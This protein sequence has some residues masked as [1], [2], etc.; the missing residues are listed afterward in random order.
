MK[1]YEKLLLLRNIPKFGNVKINKE[2]NNLILQ[3]ESLSDFVGDLKRSGV[4]EDDIKE[5]L[6]K[7]EQTKE[8]ISTIDGL[9]IITIYDD[10]YPERFNALGNSKPVILYAIGDVA[11]LREETMA[12]IGTRHPGEYTRNV[13]RRIINKVVKERNLV[14]V[15]GLALGCDMIAHE[16]VLNCNGRTIAV[17]P[18]GLNKISPKSNIPLARQI[19][20]TGGLILTEYDPQI[21]VN[22]FTP[23]QRDA[24]VAALSDKVFVLE[25]GIKSGT[26]HTVKHALKMRKPI[27]ALDS[28]DSIS[29]FS[30]N[31]EI[32]NKSLG[33]KISN[34]DDLDRF[35]SCIEYQ[36]IDNQLSFI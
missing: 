23:V 10:E 13:G 3:N 35:M 15:S 4:K 18:S 20:K 12:V 6:N 1:H 5:A 17:L 33:I 16:E 25:C 9:N 11:L 34:E 24:L 2:F 14:I 28:T 27:A 22:R 31:E 19:V 21:E 29:D 32:L 7:S 36:A 30:G 26:M 8:I